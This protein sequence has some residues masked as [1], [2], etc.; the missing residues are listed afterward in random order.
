MSES[1]QSVRYVRGSMQVLDQLLLPH[2]LVYV[3]VSSAEDAWRVTRSMQ[4]RGAPLI[5]IV[6]ALGLAVEASHLPDHDCGVDAAKA[7]LLKR[8]Q[9]LRT[10][11]PTAVNLF[12]AMDAMTE[13]V[14]RRAAADQMAGRELLLA[15]ISAAEEMLAEDLA[16]NVSIGNFG[17][18]A[19]L[20]AAA[21]ASK[22]VNVLTICN[23]GSLACAGYGTALGVVRSLHGMERLAQVYACET[24]PYNQGARLTAF[25]IVQ[26][27]L[28][29]TLIADSMASSLMA[30]GKV[31]CVIV[32]ADRGTAVR[33]RKGLILILLPIEALI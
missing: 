22:G 13:L 1:L 25:E 28:P 18:A 33:N 7:F 19:V 21:K 32:G 2:Q 24:R 9:Y 4:V 12:K 27:K 29:G 15:Y 10:S 23:T 26:D 16:T 31:D 6:A 5:A 8:L 30:A 14:E 17:A 20:E 3:D 11:R